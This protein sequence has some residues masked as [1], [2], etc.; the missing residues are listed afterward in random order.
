MSGGCTIVSGIRKSGKINI[1]FH[2]KKN[3]EKRGFRRR[4]MRDY[5]L[6]AG[7]SGMWEKGRPLLVT[8]RPLP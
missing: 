7:P 3:R 1:R 5:A 8:E 4:K 6:G 2:P